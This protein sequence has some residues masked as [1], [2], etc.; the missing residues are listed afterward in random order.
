MAHY[1]EIGPDNTVIRVIVVHDNECLD[2][3]GNESEEAGA[4]FCHATFGGTW[5]KTSYNGTI[6]KRFAGMGCTYDADRD[7]FI[8][9]KDYPSWV[10][11]AV[12]LTWVAPVPKPNDNKFYLW[13]EETVS[14]KEGLPA[15]PE[16]LPV[17]DVIPPHHIT[18]VYEMEGTPGGVE[19]PV[20][21]LSTE[22]VVALGTGVFAS[23]STTQVQVLSTAQIAPL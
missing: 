21:P 22:Q 5:V 11:D 10:F 13:D 16:P 3:N 23:L 20:A 15:E 4:A 2:A 12:E 19:A 7:A 17:S 6:R 1:A 14:W 9:R 8:P 18:P